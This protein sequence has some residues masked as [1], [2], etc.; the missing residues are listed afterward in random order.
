MSWLGTPD[1]MIG[2]WADYALA[3]GA[4]LRSQRQSRRLEQPRRA[5]PAAELAAMLVAALDALADA[6]RERR[7]DEATVWLRHHH[8]QAAKIWQGWR[9]R[10]GAARSAMSRT[11]IAPLIVSRSSVSRTQLR[12]AFED[13]RWMMSRG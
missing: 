9:V 7:L 13:R 12:A 6:E 3:A 4:G 5:R 1:P 2:L 10:R 8:P 11:E